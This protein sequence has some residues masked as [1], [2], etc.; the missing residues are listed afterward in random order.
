[1]NIIFLN[2]SPRKNGYTVQLLKLIEAGLSPDNTIEWVNTYDLNVKPC[3][4]CLNCRPDKQCC[5]PK[6]DGHRMWQMIRAADALVL[7]SP[8]YFGN[9]SGSLKTLVD[10]NVTAFEIMD[11]GGLERPTQIHRGKRAAAVTACNSPSPMS[12]LPNQGKGAINAMEAILHAGGYSV[13]GSI[14]LD[15]VAAIKEIPPEIEK[16]AK[17]ISQKLQ[18]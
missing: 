11:K 1:M 6:D 18:S 3:Q 15:G 17:A 13:V 10:R 8:T 2:G 5:L 7:G 9:I 4:G 14:I 12:K 16:Q